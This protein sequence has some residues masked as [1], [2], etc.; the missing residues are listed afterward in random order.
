M[1]FSTLVRNSILNIFVALE[2]YQRLQTILV[3]TLLMPSLTRGF[4]IAGLQSSRRRSLFT[5]ATSMII[6][7]AK[8]Y[9][10]VA[11]GPCAK[12]ALTNE[13]VDPFLQLVDDRKLQAIN[14]GPDQVRKVYGSKEDDEY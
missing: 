11:L 13:T 12:A 14:S 10:V 3:V 8:A 1:I 4:H 6:F 5:L 2:C 9:N 7:S